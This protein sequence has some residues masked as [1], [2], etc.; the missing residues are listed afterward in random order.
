MR[1]FLGLGVLLVGAGM[2]SSA[3][4]A[5]DIAIRVQVKE[6]NRDE[7]GKVDNQPVVGVEIVITDASGT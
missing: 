1:M 5:E 7:S 6:Q 2:T 3:V 4:S